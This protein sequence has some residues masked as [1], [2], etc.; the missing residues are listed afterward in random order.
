MEELYTLLEKILEAKALTRLVCSRSKDR[1]V[2][3]V[4]GRIIEL[5]GLR[6]LQLETF[7]SD[8]K[9]RQKN[10]PENTALPVLLELVQG[11]RQINLFT[12]AGE[13]EIRISKNGACHFSN[14]IK[15]SLDPFSR[16]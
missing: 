4:S 6:T 14:R 8:G 16:R 3:K 2:E 11:F 1:S 12:T 9:A 10:L 5:R 13:C 7:T 15:G